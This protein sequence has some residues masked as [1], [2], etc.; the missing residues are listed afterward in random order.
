[1]AVL[2]EFKVEII[3]DGQATVEYDDDEEPEDAISN[4]VTKYIEAVPGKQ[5]QFKCTVLPNI[6]WGEADCIVSKVYLEG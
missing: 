1:M 6:S 4:Y 3:V 5:F 2:N